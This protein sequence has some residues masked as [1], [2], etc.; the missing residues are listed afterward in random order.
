MITTIRSPNGIRILTRYELS[1]CR[2]F[3]EF[4]EGD[5]DLVQ[6][7]VK[8]PVEAVCEAL[9]SCS[10]VMPMYQV[11]FSVLGP[12]TPRVTEQQV[13]AFEFADLVELTPA[14]QRLS[15]M[16]VSDIFASFKTGRGLLLTWDVSLLECLLQNTN[17][18]LEGCI[19]GSLESLITMPHKAEDLQILLAFIEKNNVVMREQLLSQN[20]NLLL[21]A[22]RTGTWQAIRD[23][24][25]TIVRIGCAET[26]EA[27][28]G[29]SPKNARSTEYGR[30]HGEGTTWLGVDGNH[31]W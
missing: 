11:H 18:E 14:L 1:E 12:D 20:R 19:R 22:F 28:Y 26:Y 24:Y 31:C 25:G 15:R 16:M 13:A 3:A 21:M 5:E 30:T 10:K 7:D 6:I 27:F 2:W 29:R 8:M 4:G 23:I 17:V 9:S